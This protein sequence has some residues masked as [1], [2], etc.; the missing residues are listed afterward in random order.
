MLHPGGFTAAVD[1]AFGNLHVLGDLGNFFAGLEFG[2]HLG[3]ID[4]IGR[5]NVGE[6][7]LKSKSG[8][9]CKRSEQSQLFLHDVPPQVTVQF[10]VRHSISEMSKS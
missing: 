7:E 4:L 9:N 2:H 10:K 1:A 8:F 6:A 3:T 5:V